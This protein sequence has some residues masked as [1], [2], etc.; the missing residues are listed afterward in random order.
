MQIS[1]WD[2]TSSSFIY[3]YNGS[4]IA[5]SNGQSAKSI[6]PE[7]WM[8]AE[9][10]K[11]FSSKVKTHDARWPAWRV[12]DHWP[13]WSCEDNIRKRP[14]PGWLPDSHQKPG[15]VKNPGDNFT[16]QRQVRDTSLQKKKKK[17][18]R[19]RFSEQLLTMSLLWISRTVCHTKEK[20]N[21]FL[22]WGQPGREK[23]NCGT[24]AWNWI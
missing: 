5:G 9:T 2:P 19:A 4:G 17:K 14:C 10:L 13:P 20:K 11:L 16:L 12:H 24:L 22:Q 6:T 15:T 21:A 3:I 1:L 7:I 18:D 23:R 8:L